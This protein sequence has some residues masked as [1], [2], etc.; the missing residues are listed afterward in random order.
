ME[1]LI[2]PGAGNSRTFVKIV[3]NVRP[4]RV[5]VSA[6]A[7]YLCGEV[8]ERSMN[9]AFWIIAIVAA[10]IATLVIARPLLR[11]EDRAAPRAAHDA[12]VFRDQLQELERDVA[13]G[14]VSPEDAET[15]KLEISRRLLA[16]DAES[17]S[18]VGAGSA[19]KSASFGLAA[20]LMIAA[21]LGAAWLYTNHGAPGAEDQPFASRGDTIRPGQEEAEQMMAGRA[22]PPST[23]ADAEEFEQ[24]VVQLEARLAEAPDDEQGLFLYA[25]S[26]MN[27][28]RFDEAWP[29]FARLIELR[30]GKTDADIYAG[31]A[32][33]MILAA[34]GY[35]SP[36]AEAGLLQVLKRD[37]TNPSARYYLGRLHTQQGEPELAEAIWLALIEESDPNAPWVAPIRQEMAQLGLGPRGADGLSGPTREEMDA[38]SNLPPAERQAMVADMVAR[39]A[40]RLFS[41][42]GTVPEWQ[43][44]IRSYSFLGQPR[45][46][47]EAMAAAREAFAGN[48]AA[49]AALMDGDPLT[50]PPAQN[51]PAAPGPD[52]DDIAAA[53]E[54]DAGERTA[55]IQSMVGRLEERLQ[56]EGGAPE[57][58]LRLIS[59]Y[60][61]LGQTEKASAA[62]AK[63]RA[64][65]ADDPAALSMLE[66][67]VEGAPRA[68]ANAE[69]SSPGPTQEDIANAAEMPAEDRQE[70]IRGMVDQLHARLREEGRVA[71]VN[72]WG[73]LMRSYRVIG[74]N[75]A[76]EAAYQE[77]I[78]IYNDDAIGLAYLK[79]AALLNGV[80]F[81]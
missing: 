11:G 52:A 60:S 49:L 59:S 51:T 35:I 27:L 80:E 57:D 77:A 10:V 29:Q 43:R 31:L 3:V 50:A 67:A 72:D 53:A 42:G 12:Q 28:G 46:A 38:A 21:P 24:L 18:G 6:N 48:P 74:Q 55:M 1:P 79:E 73:Q 54:M 81:N 17:R 65:F 40:E 56:T 32:E 66:S 26:L 23:G 30:D 22:L 14:V 58:W 9:L 34:G 71:D 64:D 37:P 47:Q 45:K 62:Y 20:L 7:R 33:G 63:A 61:V 5:A 8:N 69:P 16:A 76:V 13:R 44:L 25:R 41:E 75:D 15:T 39:S 68:I 36:E 4:R 70:M 2:R 78:Q 19:P